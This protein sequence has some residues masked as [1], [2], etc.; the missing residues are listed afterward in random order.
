MEDTKPRRQVLHTNQH[1]KK[2]VKK[3]PK[4]YKPEEV[5]TKVVQIKKMMKG[6]QIDYMNHHQDED[7]KIYKYAET[8]M[9]MTQTLMV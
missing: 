3:P 2:Q 5:M 8:E 6:K 1:K 7:T 9:K 4:L